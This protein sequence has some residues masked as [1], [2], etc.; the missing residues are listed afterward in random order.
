ME[1]LLTILIGIFTAASFSI[2][3]VLIMLWV[4]YMFITSIISIVFFVFW[5][6]ALIDCVKRDEKDFAIGGPN[7]KLIWLLLLILVRGVVA[8]IYYLVIMR[9]KTPGITKKGK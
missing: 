9:K 4:Y 7:A 2:Y 6:I 1:E 8:V 5:I 3:G